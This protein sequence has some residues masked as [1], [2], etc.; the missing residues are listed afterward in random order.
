L[1][2]IDVRCTEGHFSE[3]VRSIHDWPATPNC[4]C[5]AKTEQV[6]LPKEIQWTV[7]PTVV[8]QAPDGS[9]RFPGDPNGISAATYR[10]QGLKEIELKGAQDVRRF[11]KFMDKHEYARA[12]RRV[13]RMQEMNELREKES[14]GQLRHNMQQ[15]S[16]YGRDV[17]RAAM[18]LN[19][20]K[21]RA[22]AKEAGFHLDVYS[23]ARSN[24]EESRDAQGRRRRD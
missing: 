7:Q 19:D 11:E 24:R 21:P 14:R 12:E 13:E 8:F 1:A 6:H 20:G 3:V 9:I 5:G 17:A 23:N 15:M 10:K 16:E 22:K 18:R 4:H 2:R